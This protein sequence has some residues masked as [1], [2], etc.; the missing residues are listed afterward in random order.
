MDVEREVHAL[1]HLYVYPKLHIAYTYIPKNACTSMKRTLGKGQGWWSEGGP[2]VHDMKQRH[3]L[4]GLAH[5]RST[6]ERIVIIRNPWERLV[7]AFQN[8]FLA[9]NDG[10]SEHAMRH[11]LSAL[12]QPGTDRGGVSFADFI[13]YLSR[14]PGRRL[15][16]HWRPQT[17]F[18]IGGYSRMLRFEHLAEDTAFLAERGL[19][20][21][22]AIGHGTSVYQ[23]DL[24]H[25]WGARPASA[26]RRQ[27]RRK[28]ALPTSA[29]M[30]D[31][32]LHALVAERF[33]ADVALFERL[34]RAQM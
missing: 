34:Q 10:P 17:D 11:G 21:E 23:T 30:Y 28:G 33:A 31:E 14:T 20:L 25:G 1:R 9:K 18:L 24:G 13:D 22:R 4:S 32:R 26:L 16:G 2:S 27:R 12:L 6:D 29:N 3:W 8:R 15:D 7:S 19:T 5:Y